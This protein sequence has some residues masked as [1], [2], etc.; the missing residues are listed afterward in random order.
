MKRIGK[1]EVGVLNFLNYMYD[2]AGDV[3]YSPAE[4]KKAIKKSEENNDDS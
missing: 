3:V 1:K 4:I 2:H